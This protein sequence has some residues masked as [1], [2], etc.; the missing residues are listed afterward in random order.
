MEQEIQDLRSELKYA[1]SRRFIPGEEDE[2]DIPDISDTCRPREWTMELVEL[3]IQVYCNYCWENVLSES[4]RNEL[5][6]MGIHDCV[7]S[8]PYFS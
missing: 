7:F 6:E 5:H 1:P 2:D 3:A 8:C 4:E